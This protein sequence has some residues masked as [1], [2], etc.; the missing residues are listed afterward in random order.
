MGMLQGVF[1]DL[2]QTKDRRATE[3]AGDTNRL[4]PI[5]KEFVLGSWGRQYDKNGEV[6]YTFFD[7]YYCSPTRLWNSLVYILPLSANRAPEAFQCQNE[8]D[9]KGWVCIYSGNVVAP[10]TGKFRFIGSGDDIIVVRFNKEIVLDYGWHSATIGSYLGNGWDDGLRKSMTG[11]IQN[12]RFKRMIAES[13]LYS[14]HK[15]SVYSPWSDHNHGLAKSPVLQVEEGNVYSIEILITEFPGIW[16]NAVLFMEQLDENDQPINEDHERYTLFR[17]TLDLP[18]KTDLTLKDQ[19]D[20]L[21]KYKPYGPVWKVVRS[22]PSTGE[23]G[24]SGTGTASQSLL[25]NRTTPRTARVN[26]NDDDLSL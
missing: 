6:H 7:K 14:K 17:T 19:E 1:Y 9:G 21:P 23:G 11:D 12:E 15:L 8:V 13:P 2:K 4:L 22:T 26:E 18:A 5:L 25:G 20:Q 24:G 10:F 16:F 3:V